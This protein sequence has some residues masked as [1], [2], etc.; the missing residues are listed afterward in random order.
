MEH[1]LRCMVRRGQFTGEYVVQ[2]ETVDGKGFSLF[3]E[4]DDIRLDTPSPLGK[5]VKAAGWLRVELID[6]RDGL[7]LVKLPTEALERGYF[8]TVRAG[9]VKPKSDVRRLEPA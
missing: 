1:W 5:E 9:D 2:G 7:M 4:A 6:Q 3:A 8:I